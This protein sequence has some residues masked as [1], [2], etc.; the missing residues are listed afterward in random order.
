MMPTDNHPL[1]L[2]YYT[3]PELSPPETVRV[4]A[5][6]GCHHIGLRLLG[7]RPEGPAQAIMTDRGLFQELRRE[8]STS[9]ITVLDAN[10]VRLVPESRIEAY[11]AFLTVAAELGARHVLATADD[12]DRSRLTDR[13]ADLCDRAG[14]HGMTVEIEFVPWLAVNDLTTARDVVTGCAAGSPGIA[15]DALHFSRSRSQFADIAAIDSVRFR[16][17]H[18]CDA[19]AEGSPDRSALLVEAVK[20]RLFPGEGGLDLV[21]LL[22]ALP[23]AIPLAIEVPT[24]Q[25]ARTA[26]ATIRVKRAVAATRAVIA[27]AL[28]KP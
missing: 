23:R 12:P 16:Y 5:E 13:L 18:I 14:S 7:G 4:A 6:A 28:S 17:A 2:A 21:G 20:E 19:P 25:L 24:E 1:S 10:T 8:L 22:R 15:I 11:D 26:P 9:G 27:A 3:V